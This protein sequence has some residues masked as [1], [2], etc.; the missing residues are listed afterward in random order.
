MNLKKY[1]LKNKKFKLGYY[2]NSAFNEM[3]PKAYF[4]Q[5]K[6]SIFASKKYYDEEYLDTRVNY[7]NKLNTFSSIQHLP[8]V[9]SNKVFSSRG[10]SKVYY[11]DFKSYI[12]YFHNEEHFLYKPGDNTEILNHP[13]FVKSR[14][15]DCSQN[16]VVLKLNAIRHF[17]FVNDDIPFKMKK[18]ILFGRMSIYQSHR[19]DFFKKHYD[20]PIC[21]IGDV[22]KNTNSEWVKNKVSISDHLHNKYILA[23]EGNDVATNL[24]WIMSSNSIAVMPRPKYETWFMEGK[25]VPD[26]HYI[27][28]KDDYS[29]LNDKLE[30]F[31]THEKE[32]MNIIANANQWTQQFR[33][34]K[35]ELLLNLL[36]MDKY[37]KWTN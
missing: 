37:F 9:L 13:T 6:N 35:R 19:E 12:R 29:D 14:H 23:L 34:S 21:D 15:I 24:K 25:L 18:D 17:N 10:K 3:I 32:A 31:S 8:D 16:E 5:E 27:C 26:Q 2:I 4:F 11:F 22:A 28:I 33:D 36:V 7:Y 20:N 30:Y 1:F